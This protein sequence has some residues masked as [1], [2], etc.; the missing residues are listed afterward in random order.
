MAQQGVAIAKPSEQSASRGCH[1]HTGIS[2]PQHYLCH[3]SPK[4]LWPS[5][6]QKAALRGL[7]SERFTYR[8]SCL[9]SAGHHQVCRWSQSVQEPHWPTKSTTCPSYTS[10]VALGAGPVSLTALIPDGLACLPIPTVSRHLD[11]CRGSTMFPKAPL[12]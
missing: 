9:S 1:T 2:Y 12:V 3:S 5:K 11:T 10:Q 6:Q 7:G 8:A 4:Q